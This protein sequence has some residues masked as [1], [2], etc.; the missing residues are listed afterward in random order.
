MDFSAETDSL[1]EQ[2]GFELLVPPHESCGFRSIPAP[3]ADEE[4]TSGESC[5]PGAKGIR[6]GGP[7]SSGASCRDLRMRR[8]A[9]RAL[10]VDRWVTPQLFNQPPVHTNL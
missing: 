4:P 3:T 6:T 5:K 7:A 10:Y 2:R 1:L 9:Q 8:C